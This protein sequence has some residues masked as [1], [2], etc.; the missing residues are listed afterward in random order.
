MNLS[1]IGS[2][3]LGE[4]NIPNGGAALN[5]E[6]RFKIARESDELTHIPKQSIFSRVIEIV[7]YPIGPG[8][9]NKT[10]VVYDV[11]PA[12]IEFRRIVFNKGL[13][14]KVGDASLLHFIDEF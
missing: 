11:T 1:T 2:L 3:S 9:D 12:W 13:F 8:I 6:R 14:T 4:A 5:F 7:E 10:P